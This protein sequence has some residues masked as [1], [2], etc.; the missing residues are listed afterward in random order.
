MTPLE[1]CEIRELETAFIGGSDEKGYLLMHR[2]GYFASAVINSSLSGFHRAVLLAGKGNNGGD[3]LVVARYLQLPCVIYSVCA[4]NDYRGEA[5]LAVRDLPDDIP[6]FQRDELFPS[7][8]LPGDIIIDGI[9]GIGFKGSTVSG[10]ERSFIASANASGLPVVS[11]D[12]P[13]GLNL[14][15]RTAADV[16]IKAAATLMFGAVKRAL[17]APHLMRMCGKLRFLD[18]GLPAVRE[19][20]E[21]CYTGNEAYCDVVH[22]P[23]EAHK[24]SRPRVLISAGCRNYQGAAKLNLLAAMRS[25]AGLVRLITSPGDN[26]G[27]PLAGIVIRCAS[28]DDVS[29]PENAL[30]DNFSLYEKSDVL[31]AGSGW[32]NAGAK[33]LADVLKFPR[34]IVMDADAL[35]ALSRHPE[36]WSYNSNAVLT[37]HAGEAERLANAFGVSVESDRR[38]FALSLARK[39]NCVVVLK[40]PGTVT[41]SPDGEVWVNSSGCS[42]L[43]TAGSGD[44]LAGV[45][46]SSVAEKGSSS[47]LCRRAAYGVWVHGM[48]GELVSG[49]VI[50]DDLPEAVGKVTANLKNKKVFGLNL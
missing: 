20:S 1:S 37:P 36:V 40:G 30:S 34:T 43:A 10:R 49:G 12:V 48:A 24:N 13:S 8:F 5:A 4:K 44:V 33:L 32:G 28:D 27:V 14:T 41:A 31:L 39:L 7:D 3:A 11:L 22:T 15:D 21:Q 23:F 25:G 17:L 2:A 9:F 18:I 38:K 26:S 29:Y 45:I 19:E 16:S 35:N 42:A 46:A 6:Y 50:A 47:T